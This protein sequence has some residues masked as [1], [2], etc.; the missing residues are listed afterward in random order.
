MILSADAGIGIIGKEGLQACRAADF[1]IT[2]FR[3]M[4]D[5]ESQKMVIDF[6]ASK[7]VVSAQSQKRVRTLRIF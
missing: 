7:T 6:N 5:F 3:Y 4:I 2:E 1:G